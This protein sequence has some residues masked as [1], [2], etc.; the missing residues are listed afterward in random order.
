MIMA[1]Q[2]RKNNRIR[3]SRASALAERKTREAEALEGM[4]DMRR[5]FLEEKWFTNSMILRGITDADRRA[6]KA[7]AKAGDKFEVKKPLPLQ[8]NGTKGANAH[9]GS[10]PSAN[11]NYR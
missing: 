6:K 1:L 11:V 8:M 9:K 3:D 5:L 10:I 4:F 7:D 2:T